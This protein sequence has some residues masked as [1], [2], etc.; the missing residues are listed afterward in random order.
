MAI[1]PTTRKRHWCISILTVVIIAIIIAI[2]VPLAVI[3][4][5]RGKH[6]EKSTVLL[7]LYIYPELN[8]TWSQ[9]YEA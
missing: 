2:V 3:S 1:F 4:P 6:G 7:P 8:T 5:K 9:L